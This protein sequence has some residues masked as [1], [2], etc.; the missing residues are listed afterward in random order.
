MLPATRA[1]L[2]FGT[3]QRATGERRLYSGR[4]VSTD[5]PSSITIR[6]TSPVFL[7]AQRT[8]LLTGRAARSTGTVMAA[9]GNAKQ[10][11]KL[12]VVG[13]SNLTDSKLFEKLTRKLVET[14]YGDVTIYDCEPD[15]EEQIAFVRRHYAQHDESYVPPHAVNS[16]AFLKAFAN[17]GVNRIL[18]VCSVG[19][20]RADKIPPHSIIMPNDYIALWNTATYATNSKLGE[21]LPTFDLDG[22][23][24]GLNALREGGFDKKMNLVDDEAVYVQTRGPRFETKAEVRALNLMGGDLVGMTG[25]SEVVLC[26]ELRIPV[27]MLC[28]C[29][30]Y[31]N[32]LV[33]EEGGQDAYTQFYAN[34]QAQMDTVEAAVG[35][36]MQALLKDTLP[37]SKNGAKPETL[38]SR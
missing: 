30:N 37:E 31:A 17:T 10:K 16:H 32:G 22:R 15:D 6:P 14:K 25:V 35:T 2:C 21:L 11:I 26:N 1:S 27:T 36:V 12:G 7:A 19:S 28:F 3:T 33:E 18:L 13:G 8:S 23:V 29:D 9:S 34:V 4:D 5:M 38:M 20:L 24:A